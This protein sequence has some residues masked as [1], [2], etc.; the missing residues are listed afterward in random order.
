MAHTLNCEC[1]EAV[2]LADGQAGE[3][4]KCPQCGRP[5]QVPA[6][7]APP[8]AP[9]LAGKGRSKLFGAAV[10][11]AVILIGAALALLPAG[12]ALPDPPEELGMI[13]AAATAVGGLNVA[14]MQGSA[15]FAEVQSLLETEPAYARLKEAGLT[16]DSVRS[17]YFAV[18]VSNPLQ[19]DDASFLVVMRNADPIDLDK[20]AAAI[21]AQEE[22]AIEKRGIAWEG[23]EYEAYVVTD[24]ERG[25]EGVLASPRGDLLFVGA[26]EMVT[27][28]MGLA[29]GTGESALGNQKL[30]DLLERGARPEMFWFGALLPA[31]E[32]R[33]LGQQ[34]PILPIRADQIE[35]VLVS[36]GPTEAEGIKLG[37]S[38]MCES[39]PVAEVALP[40]LQTLV[41]SMGQAFLELDHGAFAF[42]RVGRR[43]SITVEIPKETA[44]RLTQQAA[45]EARRLPRRELP[46]PQLEEVPDGN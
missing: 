5:V 13:P 7:D 44:E 19:Q 14:K 36:A 45:S 33:E 12:P 24:A 31:E 9:R 39:E 10:V 28:A 27:R 20:L 37:V 11:G 41:M 40:A 18:D 17:L 23:G 38:L 2:S 42:S 21:E 8:E 32:M 16:V 15:Q 30:M 4:A 6:E 46:M 3:D 1:G 25:V 29:G 26:E 43:V 34:M 22:A 35:G